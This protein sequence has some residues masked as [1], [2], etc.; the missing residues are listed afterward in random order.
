MPH[1]PHPP[2]QTFDPMETTND[3]SL[4][5]MNT[6]QQTDGFNLAVN[7]VMAGLDPSAP[8]GAP[9][10]QA[11]ATAPAAMLATAAT[12]PNSAYSRKRGLAWAQQVKARARED[13]KDKRR[14]ELEETG[15]GDRTKRRKKNDT[16]MTE[17][18]KYR[19]RLQK[20]QDS[21]A[22]A[23]YASDSYLAELEAQV[24]RYDVDMTAT[25]GQL[26]RVE[27]EREEYMRISQMAL[28]TNKQLEIELAHMREKLSAL[29][30]NARSA[31]PAPRPVPVAAPQ[32]PA[33]VP[34][35][36]AAAA[37]VAGWEANVESDG[38]EF[39]NFLFEE[40]SAANYGSADFSDLF[41]GCKP[42][43]GA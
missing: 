21:A 25:L 36:P 7:Q 4:F 39:K 15:Q 17:H 26:R 8:R 34:A 42:A 16:S 9:S 11:A 38:M 1:P 19:R 12:G 27:A 40:F 20:N 22:A 18:Q 14:R 30:G 31:A 32:A 41:S 23:R 33:A 29:G 3:T 13:F 35:A 2:A 10:A 6:F 24:E 37:T 5:P 28:D 43:P